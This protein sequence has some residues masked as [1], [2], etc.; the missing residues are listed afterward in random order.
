MGSEDDPHVPIVCETC[1]TEA[2]IPLSTLAETLER[3]NEQRHDGDELATV[4]PD[5]ADSLADLVAA[6][7]GLLGEES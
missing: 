4:D 5:V 1:D 7:M 6:D 2:R 3:H